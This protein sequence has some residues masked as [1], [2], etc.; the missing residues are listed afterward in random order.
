MFHP[1]KTKCSTWNI[2]DKLFRFT[3]HDPALQ[4][5]LQFFPF[6]IFPYVPQQR[7]FC[8]PVFFGV[9][10]SSFMRNKKAGVPLGTPAFAKF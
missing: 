6:F 7:C 1:L 8:S 4:A 9:F 5:V 2:F 10:P 3:L